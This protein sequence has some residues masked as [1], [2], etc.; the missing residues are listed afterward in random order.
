MARRFLFLFIFLAVSAISPGT[1]DVLFDRF[2]MNHSTIGFTVP[3]IGGLSEVQGKF[4]EFSVTL[5][6]DDE[7]L[8]LSSVVAEIQTA[9]INT[10]IAKRDNHL[11]S[12]DFF[13][14]GSYPTIRFESSRVEKRGDQWVVVGNLTMRA[15][16]KEIGIPFTV[17]GVNENPEL[18]IGL[19]ATTSLNRRDYGMT[20]KHPAV[21][22]FVSDEI[23]IEIRLLSKLTEKQTVDPASD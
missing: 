23:G 21:S 3:I 22:A 20:W 8:T 16:T 9:S 5:R 10:G 18:L 19:S 2:D 13:D 7:D 6:Y 11:R 17:K 15:H 1:A 14:A 4:T 12:P